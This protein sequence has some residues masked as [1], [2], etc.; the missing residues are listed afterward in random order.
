MQMQRGN[1]I[2]IIVHPDETTEPVVIAVDGKGYIS[3]VEQYGIEVQLQDIS[4]YTSDGIEAGLAHIFKVFNVK[5][6]HSLRGQELI[7]QK[8]KLS[9]LMFN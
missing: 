5:T 1:G 9:S 8:I 4:Q 2:N 3:S 7:E 6:S